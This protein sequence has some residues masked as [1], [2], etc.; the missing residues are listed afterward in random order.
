MKFQRPIRPSVPLTPQQVTAY[1]KYQTIKQQ[2]LGAL[3]LD[4]SRKVSLQ[5]LQEQNLAHIMAHRFN[6][7]KQLDNYT[8]SFTDKLARWL[9][10]DLP[11][12]I[13]TAR[14]L[15]ARNREQVKLLR[16]I[17]DTLKTACEADGKSTIAEWPA[18]L[19]KYNQRIENFNLFKF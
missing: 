12:S 1:K 7:G 9:G 6:A 13:K 19:K 17:R 2:L 8:P 11:V 18:L 15:G 16:E 10:F 14:F 5:M 3:P 4:P